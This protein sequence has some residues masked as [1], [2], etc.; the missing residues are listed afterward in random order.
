VKAR[1]QLSRELVALGL[2]GIALAL[3]FA[4]ERFFEFIQIGRPLAGGGAS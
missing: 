2:A 1:P 4:P 3:A